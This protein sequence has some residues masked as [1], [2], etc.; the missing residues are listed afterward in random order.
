MQSYIVHGSVK[1]SYGQEFSHQTMSINT[2]APVVE[3]QKQ[4]SLQGKKKR[5]EF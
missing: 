4:Q 1:I 2:T 3:N 5:K